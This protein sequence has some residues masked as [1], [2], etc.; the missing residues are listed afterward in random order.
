[1]AANEGCAGELVEDCDGG[2]TVPYNDAEALADAIASLIHDGEFG[3]RARRGVAY[4]KQ[5]SWDATFERELRFYREIIA[6]RRDGLRVEP[7]FHGL[8]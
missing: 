5:L 7:G 3:E 6:R 8:G 2:L 1:V 4:A